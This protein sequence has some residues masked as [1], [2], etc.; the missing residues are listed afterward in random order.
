MSDLFIMNLMS[1][2]V[3][4]LLYV[5]FL[6][7][8]KMT[9]K[10]IIFGIVIP[11]DRAK[12]KEI[13]A[14]TKSYYANITI[15]TTVIAVLYFVVQNTIFNNPAILVAVVFIIIF[16]YFLI[17]LKANSRIKAYKAKNNLLANKKQMVYVNTEMSQKLRNTAVLSSFWFI[18]PAIIA[19]C[20]LILPLM[21]YDQ[22][23]S[24]IGIHWNIYGVADNFIDKSVGAVITNGMMM[25]ILVG[26]LAFA[27]YSIAI[28]KNKIDVAQPMSSSQK[29][30][31]FKRF[32]S[33][34]L[35]S[36][37]LVISS[38]ITVFNLNSL[39]LI[40]VNLAKITPVLIVAFVLIIFVPIF[41]TFKL[42]Q[43][44]SN[45]KTSTNEDIDN[46]VSNIDD[47]IF[48][49]LGSIY[50][51]P[52]DPSLFV[53][54]RFGVGWTLNFGNKIAIAI[55]IGFIILILAMCIFPLIFS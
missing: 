23:P 33:I 38:L 9:R 36:L 17:F 14:A 34:M 29:L 12:D 3:I 1:A 21:K 10:D 16:V 30:Y 40:S 5:T 27:N 49:K 20:N 22:L 44:G 52:N 11:L 42:G 35:F 53:E 45:L 50:Y 37:T 54:K 24:K 51:N 6:L 2:L 7:T 39:N 47:D 31:K 46:T 13:E 32:N 8:P 48:W 25:V 28:S 19:A 4:G 55:S 18:I 26:I 15:F 41:L 43:G